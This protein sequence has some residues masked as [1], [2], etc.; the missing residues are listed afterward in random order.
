MQA[1]TAVLL[2]LLGSAVFVW[3]L[4]RNPILAALGVALFLWWYNKPH[5]GKGAKGPEE[6]DR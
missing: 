6:K 1:Q 2:L 4:P 3:L 5:S